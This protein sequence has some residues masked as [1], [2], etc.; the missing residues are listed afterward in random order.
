MRRDPKASRVYFIMARCYY[1]MKQYGKAES[2]YRVL[3]DLLPA[4]SPKLDIVRR[5][6]LRL[7]QMQ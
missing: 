4:R 1:G 3:L 6:I 7:R 2:M 5:N